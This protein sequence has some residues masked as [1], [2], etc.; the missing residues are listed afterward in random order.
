MS[1]HEG[2]P[3]PSYTRLY[4]EMRLKFQRRLSPACGVQGLCSTGK[5][6]RINLNETEC[7]SLHIP[8]R[9]CSKVTRLACYLKALEDSYAS[10]TMG[11][12]FSALLN[13]P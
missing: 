12:R 8:L 5:V 10:S 11:G 6:H 2:A 7:T 3:R 9:L 4:S 13:K 1:V